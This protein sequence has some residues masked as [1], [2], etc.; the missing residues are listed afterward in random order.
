MCS[1]DNY[2]LW[3]EGFK[4]EKQCSKVEFNTFY[5]SR[6]CLGFSFE[7]WL[8][9]SFFVLHASMSKEQAK[10]NNVCFCNTSL[11]VPSIDK[12]IVRKFIIHFLPFQ[13]ADELKHIHLT[14]LYCKYKKDIH[15]R[16]NSRNTK[17]VHMLR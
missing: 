9:I 6:I 14:L 4:F 11:P 8:I 1:S 16:T 15:G 3:W 17:S 13:V 2:I 7:I 12:L 10:E 5:F